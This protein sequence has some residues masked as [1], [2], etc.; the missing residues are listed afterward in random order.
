MWNLLYEDGACNLDWP[1]LGIPPGGLKHQ[2]DNG[3]DDGADDGNDD[4]DGA[5]YNNDDYDGLR[6]S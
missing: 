5:D 6:W 3:E 4:Y 1:G 2:I